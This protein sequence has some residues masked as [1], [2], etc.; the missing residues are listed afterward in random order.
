MIV[1]DADDLG[2]NHVISDMCQSHDCRDKLDEFHYINPNFKATLFAIP[3]EMTYELAEWCYANRQW[4]ELAVHGIKHS[5]NYECEKMTYDEFDDLIRPL[6]TMIDTYF[7]RGFKAPGWQISDD[8]YDW[9]LRNGWWV[10]D[11]GYNDKR[12]PSELPAYV[13][14]DGNFRKYGEINPEYIG[15][16]YHTWDC[17]GNGVYELSDQIKQDIQGETEFKFVSEILCQK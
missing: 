7:V 3:A 2:S 16:H 1:W 13:N 5:S 15:K 4:I 10:A 17:M 6:S 8:I 11:Q 14:Y 9:L 12:R